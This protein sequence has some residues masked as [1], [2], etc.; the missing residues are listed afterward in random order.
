MND[1]SQRAHARFSASAAHRWFACPGS[2]ALCESL[3]PAPESEY[4]KEGTQAHELLEGYLARWQA[5]HKDFDASDRWVSAPKDMRDAV[6]E[7]V[8]YVLEILDQHDDAQL[9]LEKQFQIPSVAAPGDVWG[10][11][12]IV[13]YVPSWQ[14]V[15][16]I[17]YK[18]GAGKIVDVGTRENPNKQLMFYAYGVVSS[19]PDWDVTEVVLSIV[20]PRVNHAS[21]TCYA[22]LTVPTL[23]IQNFWF[24]LEEEILECLQPNAPLI[25]GEEQC[26]F[27]SA[28]V[29][30]PARE[31]MALAVIGSTFDDVRMITKDSF[32]DVEAMSVDRLGHVLAMADLIENWFKAVRARGMQLALA[33]THVPGF[34]IVEAMPRRSFDLPEEPND[35]DILTVARNLAKIAEGR[36]AAINFTQRKLLGIGDT[37]KLLKDDARENAPKG[38]KKEAVEAVTKQFAFLTTKKSSGTLSLVPDDDARPAVNRASDAF[39][40]VVPLPYIT[41]EE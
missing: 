23:N 18:H 25:P 33:G 39:A 1:H 38:K 4:A 13:I 35:E 2:V 29:S 10:T 31:K 34:K 36:I 37:E 26:Q 19:F 32:P 7:C 12:D 28:A 14:L 5:G 20:Q 11:S 41:G 9:Y 15:Y 27:C 6:Q 30:C 17:D 22:E 40:G 24:A 21:N 16:I 8:D 3:P